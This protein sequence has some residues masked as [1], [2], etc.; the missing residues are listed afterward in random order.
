MKAVTIDMVGS[1]VRKNP[2]PV[3]K[4]P[5]K[6]NPDI[7]ID[8]WVGEFKAFGRLRWFGLNT[9]QWGI[10]HGYPYELQS[11]GQQ[12]ASLKLGKTRAYVVTD[13]DEYGNP[14]VE[15]WPITGLKIYPRKN[16]TPK[17]GNPAMKRA[18]R[19][20]APQPR[21]FRKVNPRKIGGSVDYEIQYKKPRGEWSRWTVLAY[22]EMA[23]Q[24]AQRVAQ[25]QPTWAIRVVE[26]PAR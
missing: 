24:V 14:V 13:E 23:K 12:N 10:D 5:L 17:R 26:I 15:V 11:I 22:S 16:P 7:H 9:N 2:A 1:A 6:V 4:N 21:A 8:K 25:D 3:R 19:N 18:A 20:P